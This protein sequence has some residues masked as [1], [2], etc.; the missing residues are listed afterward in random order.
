M[1]DLR[2][3]LEGTLFEL[4]MV[5]LYW[6]YILIINI[7]LPFSYLMIVLFSTYG[8]QEAVKIALTGF[9]V[10]SSFSI[11]IYTIGHRIGNLFE[12][13]VLELVASLP[14]GFQELIL[15]IILSYVILSLPAVLASIIG[16]IAVAGIT[17]PLLMVTGLLFMY[18]V[19]IISGVITGL[20]VRNVRKLD[21]LLQVLVFLAIIFTPAFYEIPDNIYVIPL[22]ANPLTHVVVLLRASIGIASTITPIISLTYL[23]VIMSLSIVFI[24][25]FMRRPLF[26]IIEKK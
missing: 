6:P 3:V 18:A 15:S 16:L 20:S 2:N 26:T 14:I 7:L 11:L 13:E 17:R 10:I 25:H 8:S 22:A 1:T 9:L 21:P 19:S 4:K 5:R 12:D 23:I 24:L